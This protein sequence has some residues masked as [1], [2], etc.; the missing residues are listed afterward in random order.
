MEWNSSLYLLPP[1]GLTKEQLFFWR[2]KNDKKW[3]IENFLFIKDKNAELVP[4]K[5]NKAQ[6]MVYEKYLE[7]LRDEKLPRFI[8]LKSRQQGISTFTEGM[9][10]SDTSTSSFKNTFIIAHEGQASTNLFNMSKLFYTEL[11]D[12]IKPS[13]SRSNEKALIFEDKESK[14][15]GLRSRFTIGTANT[16]EGG[17]GNTFNNVHV[18]EVAFFPNAEKTLTAIIQAVPDS[19]NTM[20]VL[21]STANGVGDYFHKQ[22]LMAKDGVSEFI[23]IFLPWSFDPTCTRNF[24]SDEDK[25]EFIKSIEMTYKDFDGG[26]TH[27]DEWYLK[28]EYE[29]TYEQLYWRR[30]A[31]NNKCGG[32]IE[33][34]RQEYPINDIEAFLSTGRP[35]FNQKILKEYLTSCKQGTYGYVDYTN[36]TIGFREEEKGFVQI[37]DKPKPGVYYCM[38][39]DVA[40][41]LEKGD[42]SDAYIINSETCDVVASW[43]GHIDPDLYGNELV[44]L[45]KYYNDAYIGVE[46]NNHGLTTLKSI[47]RLEYWNLF[48]TKTLDKISDKIT[49]KMGWTT[50]SRTKPLMID[51]LQEFV[52]EKHIGIK[53]KECI[54]QMTT[55]VRE[56]NGSTN[57]QV[58][59]YDDRVMALA[60]ALQVLLDGRSEFYEVEKGDV[61]KRKVLESFAEDEKSQLEVCN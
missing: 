39:A 30:W 25:E 60:V 49:T 17:R 50:S 36:G 20:V 43:H 11:P 31:I 28:D 10:F 24:K 48:Y 58:G 12:I 19:M 2:V 18:S 14:T 4:F 57:A 34:F 45:A 44:K 37:W 40:E 13:V 23:P 3:Y 27:T 59:C 42:F 33:M 35:V 1:K 52:R 29:L 21:E 32:S 22:W 54:G 15:G 47:Q 55:Y 46:N 6:T 53:D 16:L 5:F 51:K 26:V 8:C 38:G 9:M 56:D 7:C 61:K 41:G